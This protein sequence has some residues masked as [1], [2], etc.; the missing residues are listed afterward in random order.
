M[1]T[2]ISGLQTAMPPRQSFTHNVLNFSSL[3]SFSAVLVIQW[4]V[5]LLIITP[6]RRNLSWPF[7]FDTNESILL[8]NSSMVLLQIGM[9]QELFPHNFSYGSHKSSAVVSLI[10]Q[11]FRIN[12]NHEHFKE[13]VLFYEPW[14]E[15]PAAFL[16][17]S[18]LYQDEA[19][20]AKTQQINYGWTVHHKNAC[21]KTTVTGFVSVPKRVFILGQSGSTGIHH[22]GPAACF[23]FHKSSWCLEQMYLAH[24]ALDMELEARDTSDC[25]N[26]HCLIWNII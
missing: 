9:D 19:T 21:S 11:G 24:R 5:I 18:W 4:P 23:V 13:V 10:D 16:I 8:F 25:L 26:P 22:L 15:T 20:A 17:S 6:C 1:T 14:V 3:C 7:T 12:N 2:V